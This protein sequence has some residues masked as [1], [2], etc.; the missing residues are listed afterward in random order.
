MQNNH[1]LLKKLIWFRV[2]PKKCPI[3]NKAPKIS[4][5]GLEY[6]ITYCCCPE[7]RKIVEARCCKYRYGILSG[8]YNFVPK[9]RLK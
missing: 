6:K 2:I 5:N 4:L 3:H 7:F 1:L 9:S 8:R